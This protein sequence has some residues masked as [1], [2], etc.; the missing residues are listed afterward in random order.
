MK[1]INYSCP[2]WLFQGQKKLLKIMK[3]SIVINLLF[4]LSLSAKSGYSQE[5][6]FTINLND[7][8]V[9]DVI[10]TIEAR[11]NY[12]FF[13]NDELS[14]V[15]RKV[16]VN[17]KEAPLDKI[18]D[19]L[20]D[21]TGIIFKELENNLIVITPQTSLQQQKVSG[22][23]TD[24]S[25]G[26]TLPGV[27]IQVKGTTIGTNSDADGN[28]TIEVPSINAEL[29]FSFVG[30]VTEKITLSGNSV[31][32]IKLVQD[33]LNLQEIVVIGY[34]ARKKET[35][36]GS[37]SKIDGKDMQINP[38]PNVS[39]S[40]GGK[41]PGIISINT[42]GQ[43]GKDDNRILIRGL[44]TLG[45]NDPL[46]I[47]DGI[48]VGSID[49]LDP[50]DIESLSVLKDASAAIYGSKAANG[51]IIVT[52]KRGITGKPKIEYRYNYGLSQP[53]FKPDIANAYDYNTYLNAY[54]VANKEAD[55]Q[56][57]ASDLEKLKIGNDPDNYFAN[58]D[59]WNAAVRKVTPVQR[60][61]ASIRGGTEQLK[62]FA[63]VGFLNQ[64]SVFV[65][66]A[67]KYKQGN[68][69]TNID[70]QLNKYVKLGI[71]L[72]GRVDSRTDPT[73]EM[74][75]IWWMIQATNPRY[76][77]HFSNGLPWEGKQEGWNPV[78]MGTDAGGKVATN[79]NS[80]QTLGTFEVKIPWVQGLSVDGWYS[81]D[82]S[83]GNERRQQYPWTV[84][85]KADANGVHPP[86]IST[87]LGQISLYEKPSW[88]NSQTFNA[89]LNYAKKFGQ[90]ELSAFV[91]YEQNNYEYKWI[92]SYRNDII[93]TN[94]DA[95]IFMGTALG[96]VADGSAEKNSRQNYI[97]RFSYN[98]AS[99]YYIDFTYRIDGSPI[100]PEK[101]RFGKFPGLSA[102]WRISEESFMKNNAPFIN[103]LKLRASWGQL[104]NDR[105]DPYQ[106]LT[107]YNYNAGQVFMGTSGD[108]LAGFIPGVNA[109]PN[110]TWEVAE[111][112][113]I[114]IDVGLF[115]QLFEIELDIYQNSRNK[116]LIERNA[117]IPSYVGLTLPSEN[118]GKMK[119]QGVEILLTHNKKF[120][121]F[122]YSISGNFS[123]NN[124]TVVDIDETPNVLDW[125]KRTGK[126]FGAELYY[127]T[128][129]L[130]SQ[131]DIDNPAIAKYG[132]AAAGDIKIIDIKN[133]SM[134]NGDDRIRMEK[135]LDVPRI[136]YGF[137]IKANFK[138]FDLNM[139][140]QGAEKV[141]RYLYAADI[142]IRGNFLKEYYTDYWSETNL[143]GRWPKANPNTF[144]TTNDNDFYVLP[145]GYLR[146]SSMEFG[147]TLPKALTSMIYI[148]KL[149]VYFSGSN[150]FTVYNKLKHFDP[151]VAGDAGTKNARGYYYPK[152]RIFN[153]GVNVTF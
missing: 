78:I 31:V 68:Y 111:N 77:T 32:N 44:G 39:S 118:L 11:S 70:W 81:M 119:N 61:T 98:F 20:F 130:Y 106:Y 137:G 24:A 12:R 35:L 33:I 96:Q 55:K 1:K 104:G 146:L 107:A 17:F 150:L 37:V 28:F 105:V 49:R 103:R 19:E 121:D 63:S 153:F 91:A 142:G 79:N 152:Q 132:G 82:R 71:N 147:Y 18:L 112:R 122:A 115:D 113:N 108:L 58:T 73:T 116:I 2:F 125:Q 56:M 140:F 53:T 48:D 124:N 134:I 52:T 67:D 15:S 92:S 99:K 45:D 83:Q 36:T 38:S 89:K 42:S 76:P 85:G 43:P 123:Y 90:H 25:N 8:T 16:N 46:I 22:T 75:D 148:E 84:Y 110:I 102:A 86:A 5:N 93:A 57:S 9:K 131:T 62:Y 127:Q 144:G 87:R 50:S 128:D 29:I 27:N 109:N 66:G 21:N 95:Q 54:F 145:A 101:K 59:F 40:L 60:H 74:R 138:D 100:F 34:G 3:L 51:V 151:E 117:S 47:V 41:I 88:S 80:Y 4:V 26:T 136:M 97:S 30:Y 143:N 72:S 120:G 94:P 114:G 69:R 13:Y 65:N 129:G 6:T 135:S 14:D 126:P 7:V 141:Y 23:V 10:K 133:D 149:R 64:E 139:V